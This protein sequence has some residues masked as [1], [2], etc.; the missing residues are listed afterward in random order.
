MSHPRWCEP[1]SWDLLKYKNALT[2]V[3]TAAL[4]AALGEVTLLA[5]GRKVLSITEER[6]G[7]LVAL[8][9]VPFPAP[10]TAQPSPAVSGET[11]GCV[12]FAPQQMQRLGQ[13]SLKW[14][15]SSLLVT[16]LTWTLLQLPPPPPPPTRITT[17]VSVHLLQQLPQPGTEC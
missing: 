5:S 3:P 9:G 15:G 16:C 6:A 1:L 10:H 4:P 14:I 13:G 17:N 11:H 2:W 7:H 12:L 8:A